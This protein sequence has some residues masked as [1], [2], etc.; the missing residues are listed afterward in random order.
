MQC[1]LDRASEPDKP[2]RANRTDGVEDLIIPTEERCD[3][4]RES[5]NHLPQTV[6]ALHRRIEELAD[7]DRDGGKD[8]L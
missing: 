3:K 1:R 6:N 4:C 2:D 7:R 5:D 8:P